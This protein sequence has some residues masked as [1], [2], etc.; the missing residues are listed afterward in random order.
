MTTRA[1][2]NALCRRRLSDTAA[3]LTWS[4]LQLNQWIVDAVAEYSLHFPRT[5]TA[6]IAA[7]VD[8]HEYSLS[9]YSGLQ[10]VLKVEYPA[11]EDPPA[12]LERADE[13]GAL[14]FYTGD[15]YDLWGDP[16][17]T[18]VI[19]PS[20]AA[21]ETI[22]ITY[23]ADHDFPDDD[24]DTLTIPDRHLELIVLFVRWAAAQER[25]A[26]EA[27]DPDP[28]TI[29]LSMLSEATGRAE[30]AYLARLKAYKAQ[31]GQPTRFVRWDLL[32][33]G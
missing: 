22:A 1:A 24:A 12:Y 23:A 32:D 30:R 14:P 11:G 15:C 4:E 26:N 28:T 13:A 16:P 6:T 27:K 5:L 17:A 25:E 19:G 18:L 10:T 7:V 31:S 3:P 29:L 8:Q 9:A 2:L 21:G 33:V 20:P